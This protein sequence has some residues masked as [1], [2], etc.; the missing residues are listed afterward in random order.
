[1]TADHHGQGVPV[2]VAASKSPILD[3]LGAKTPIV[4]FRSAERAQKYSEQSD[5]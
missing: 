5:E 2:I 3:G 1:M 4:I